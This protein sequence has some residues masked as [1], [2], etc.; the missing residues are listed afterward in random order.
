MRLEGH[1][2]RMGNRGVEYKI[3][4]LIPDGKRPLERCRTRW[5]DYVKMDL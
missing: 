2:E 3:W 5:D 4:V 1:V